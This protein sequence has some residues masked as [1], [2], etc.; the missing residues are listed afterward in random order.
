MAII[1]PAHFLKFADRIAAQYDIFKSMIALAATPEN[2][3]TLT[4]GAV[5]NARLLLDPTGSN[6]SLLL[7]AKEAGP[8][9]NDISIA[10][11]DPSANDQSLVISVLDKE[12]VVS[13]ATG[14]GGAI[15]TTAEELKTALEINLETLALISITEVGLISGTVA[16]VAKTNLSGGLGNSAL[17]IT[18][19]DVGSEGNDITISLVDPN[20]NSQSLS[21]E[22]TD[23][24]IVI[25]LETDG[26][27]A[28]TTTAEEIKDLIESDY[29]TA[30]LVTVELVGDG[31]G[32]VEPL[33]ETNL[34][35]AVY[36][37]YTS[38]VLQPLSSENN[39][40]DSDM[41]IALTNSARVLDDGLTARNAITGIAGFAQLI[42]AFSSYF[43]R[44][45]QAGL[46][47]GYLTENEILVHKSFNDV[48]SFTTGQPL[49]AI[50]VFKAES[51]DLGTVTLGSA[52]AVT[53]TTGGATLGSGSG[54]ASDTNLAP[55]KV[56][57]S[58]TP[59]YK[60]A[61]LTVDP[62]GSSNAVLF[63]AVGFG[64]LGNAIT[65]RYLDPAG[66]N[67]ALSLS[68]STKAITISLATGSGGAITSTAQQIIDAV[69]AHATISKLVVA[70][71]VDLLAT[72]VVTAMSAT[73]LTGG[74][75][76]NLQTDLN[77]N[78]TVKNVDSEDVEITQVRFDSGSVPGTYEILGQ[79]ASFTTAAFATVDDQLT[80]VARDPGEAGNDISITYVDPS[81]INQSLSVEL[82]G[83]DITVNL[84]TNGSGTIT[85]TAA[86]VRTAL[87]ADDD[88]SALIYCD[89]VGDGSDVV[90]A[91]ATNTLS[92]GAEPDRYLSL[93][94]AEL[95]S[96]G[97]EGD[98]L[99]LSTVV[100]RSVHT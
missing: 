39:T 22:T 36:G 44:V 76:P 69:N 7:V 49:N 77:F 8:D 41:A 83:T 93:V 78:I 60:K 19:R 61:S 50:S 29:E 31:S 17:T 10:L 92:D 34:S 5:A 6:N 64:P 33:D 63:T 47:Q 42:S 52:L 70:T 73:N 51:L 26:G 59:V 96:G 68:L 71:K 84:A 67:Q 90:E 91:L 85:S 32:V 94:S 54:L 43:S 74:S 86:Q 95:E 57:V 4:V 2:R 27:G 62:T 20:A 9:G 13:L 53:T 14:S 28:I 11:L 81:A 75:G 82:D 16:A 15:T 3:A 65:V 79:R 72:G 37:Y 24:S 55:Q 21:I 30:S 40:A 18:A 89:L 45:S 87:L 66:N 58:L 48:F 56:K 80:F 97:T 100:E 88:I 98:K 23:S 46:L 12:I 25:S 1:Q 38:S 35:G 99:V